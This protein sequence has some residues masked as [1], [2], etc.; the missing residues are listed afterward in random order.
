MPQA[1]MSRGLSE[2]GAGAMGMA[3]TFGYMATSLVSPVIIKKVGRTKKRLRLLMLIYG[4]L[5]VVFLAVGWLAPV[6]VLLAVTLFIEGFLVMGFEALIL[7]IPVSMKGI[8]TRYSATATGLIVTVQLIGAVTI[9]SYIAAP[10]AGDNY[11]LIYFMLSAVGLIFCVF[12]RFLPIDDL[13]GN[14]QNAG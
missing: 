1:L 10:I 9:T 12:S 11:H 7:A 2:A 8:G 13:L 4:L 3:L 6:G 14:K 5:M